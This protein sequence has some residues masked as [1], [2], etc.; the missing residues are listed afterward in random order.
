MTNQNK[1]S[2]AAMILMMLVSF[3]GIMGTYNTQAY[4]GTIFFSALA[5]F[6]IGIIMQILFPE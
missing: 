6:G 4:G 1:R 3:I 5:G 2:I